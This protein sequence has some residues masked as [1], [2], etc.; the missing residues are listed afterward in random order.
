MR[1]LGID[2]CLRKKRD[3]NRKKGAPSAATENTSTNPH[4]ESM[5]ISTVQHALRE[6]NGTFTNSSI[7]R[8]KPSTSFEASHNIAQQPPK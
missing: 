6:K 3:N 8:A 5:I 7:S 2:R 4:S 1:L